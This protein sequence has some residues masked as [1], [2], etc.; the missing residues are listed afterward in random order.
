ML[1]PQGATGT[2]IGGQTI[3]GQD[4]SGAVYVA[5]SNSPVFV[6]ANAGRVRF[7]GFDASLI[8]QVRDNLS[9]RA[10]AASAHATDLGTK[11]APGLENGI[12]PLNGFVALRWQPRRNVWLEAYSFLADAQRRFSDNDLQQARIGGIRTKDEITNF[13]NNGAVARGLVINGVLIPTGEALSQVLSRVLGPDPNTRVPLFRKNPGYAT[14]NFRAGYQFNERSR[15]ALILENIMDKNYRTMGSGIDSPG[16]N[17]M[18]RYV[19]EF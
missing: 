13:F 6:R 17:L 16:M 2:P 3:I 11:A 9:V 5:L 14:L 19:L 18:L 1:L 4:A 7:L 12:P 10:N 8:V 15:I